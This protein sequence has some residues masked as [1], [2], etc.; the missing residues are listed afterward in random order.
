MQIEAHNNLALLIHRL[1]KEGLF[2]YPK[3]QD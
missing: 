2:K 1:S 3:N